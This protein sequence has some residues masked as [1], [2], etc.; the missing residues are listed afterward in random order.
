MVCA[1]VLI[2]LLISVFVVSCGGSSTRRTRPA[3]RAHS[4]RRR[5]YPN[6][7]RR[8][9]PKRPRPSA[10]PTDRGRGRRLQPLRHRGR[11]TSPVRSPSGRVP[12]RRLWPSPEFNQPHCQSPQPTA[13]SSGG[14][15]HAIE[16]RLRRRGTRLSGLGDPAGGKRLYHPS[17]DSTTGGYNMLDVVRATSKLIPDASPIWV[18]VGEVQGGQAAWALNELS[19]NYGFQHLRGTVSISPIADFPASPTPPPGGSPA[20]NVASTSSPT[21][22]RCQPNTKPSSHSMTTAA[23]G[24]GSGIYCRT[25]IRATTPPAMRSSPKSA[26]DDLRP[27]SPEALAALKRYMRQDDAAARPGPGADA[28]DVRRQ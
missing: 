16:S 8:Y 15:Q 22:R 1:R 7:T 24:Q 18:A 6:P 26:P 23:G 28:G 3:G 12:H 14:H 13:A 11:S 27:A 4:S 2:A 17:L 10:S 9:P 25:A 20:N 5:S 19:D 21:W